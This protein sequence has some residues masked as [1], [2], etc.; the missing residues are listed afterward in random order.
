MVEFRFQD[1]FPLAPEEA[2]ARRRWVTLA[3]RPVPTLS[4]ED[5]VLALCAHG[6]KHAWDILGL[7]ADV[8]AMVA[9]SPDLDWHAIAARSE[10]LGAGRMVRLGLRLAH[11]LL[12]APVPSTALAARDPT[13]AALAREVTER[14][15]GRATAE[16]GIAVELNAQPDRL[17][18]ADVHLMRARELGVKVAIDT[19]AHSRETL[20]FMR[21][22]VDQARRGWLEPKDIVNCMTPAALQRWL[23][24]RRPKT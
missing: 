10:A 9:T 20:A 14:L 15:R 23:R 12:A 22:G 3:G 17:D 6:A 11:D 21:Y 1:L 18:L 13:A 7:V 24:R 5:T 2:I 4:R 16:L 8:A 19:D